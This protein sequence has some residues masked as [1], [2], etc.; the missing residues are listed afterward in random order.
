MP[1]NIG[2]VWPFLD[3]AFLDA[4]E[5]ICL[6]LIWG[7]HRGEDIHVSTSEST[8]WDFADARLFWIKAR[9]DRYLSLTAQ[10]IRRFETERRQADREGHTQD[11]VVDVPRPRRE[12]AR[13][14]GQA[15][16]ARVRRR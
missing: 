10:A 5:T 1:E 13:D 2:E 15:G 14:L 3:D 4:Y 7:D 8:S 12:G 6:V 16:T 9:I 11:G